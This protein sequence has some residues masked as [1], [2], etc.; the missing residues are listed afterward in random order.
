MYTV[1]IND[2]WVEYVYSLT[3][4]DKYSIQDLIDIVAKS[5]K[6]KVKCERGFQLE[7]GEWANETFPKATNKTII[8]HMKREI[9]ELENAQNIGEECADIYHMLLHLAYRNGF[10]LY[11][12]ARAKFKTNK[13]RKWGKPDHE[14]V[15]EHVKEKHVP[16]RRRK[17]DR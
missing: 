3:G 10:D 16:R 8:A 6:M 2:G 7:V 9:V 15:V 17:R 5:T 12:A 11:S 14:G 13:L 4:S 1:K